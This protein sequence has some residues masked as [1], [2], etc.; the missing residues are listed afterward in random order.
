[1]PSVLVTGA[2][3]GLG[4]EWV[5]QYA[6]LEW[7]VHATCRH[8]A[9]ASKLAEVV[10]Q[11]PG[12]S[13]HRLDITD[14]RDI[15]ALRWQLE[16]EPLDVL[17]NNAGIYLDKGAPMIGNLHF[18]DWLLTLETNTLGPLRVTEALVDNLARGKRRLVVMLSSHMGSISDIQD[19]DS[20]YYRSSKAALN[21]AA[22]GLAVA[23]QQR[24]IGILLFH[25]G[26]VLTRMGGEGATLTTTQSVAAMRRLVDG[27]EMSRSGRFYNYDGS[28]LP[29]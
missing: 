10:R 4:L 11:Y 8:P 2:N 22:Q 16:D 5:R 25:P 15:R 19:D 13:L 23:L 6:A 1:M 3:R 24:R 12:V 26:H 21:A 18:D 14:P 29:W 20:F 7:R 27:F 17:V 28:P 9:E